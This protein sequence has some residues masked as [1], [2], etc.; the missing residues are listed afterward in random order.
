MLTNPESALICSDQVIYHCREKNKYVGGSSRVPSNKSNLQLGE[1]IGFWGERLD[2]DMPGKGWKDVYA[3]MEEV[4]ILI[5]L[6]L[7]T[8]I[9][10]L[11]IN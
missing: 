7:Q 4:F 5:R 8:C 10:L 6:R 3:V 1:H 11:K 9:N 2:G